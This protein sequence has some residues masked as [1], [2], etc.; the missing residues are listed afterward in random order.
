MT[1]F[2]ERARIEAAIEH[3][4]RSELLWA[5]GYCRMRLAI[6]PRQ[7]HQKYW[8]NMQRKVMAALASGSKSA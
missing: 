6:A 8:K 5:E 4:N 3:R 7:D 2:K 1:R